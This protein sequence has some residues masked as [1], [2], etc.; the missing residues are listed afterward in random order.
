M[1]KLLKKVFAYE[2]LKW[3][4]KFVWGDAKEKQFSFKYI[5]ILSVE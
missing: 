4:N 1:E 2:I 3:Q 5:I